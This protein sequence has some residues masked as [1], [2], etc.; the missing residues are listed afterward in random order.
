MTDRINVAE[1]R[2][3]LGAATP[4]PW[5]TVGEQSIC[6][7]ENGF[8]EVVGP[9]PVDCMAY[10]YGGSSQLEWGENDRALIVALRNAAPAL[11]RVLDAAQEA[12][13][14][15]RHFSDSNDG[16]SPVT[17]GKHADALDL[18]LDAFDFTGADHA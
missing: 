16:V 18:P 9:G 10:C 12:R 2:R 5:G 14:T 15:L 3:L 13:A 1:L 7:D 11:L 6:G 17:A 4:G 8:A